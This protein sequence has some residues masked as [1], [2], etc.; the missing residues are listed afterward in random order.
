[1]I[2]SKNKCAI[3]CK[4]KGK[5]QTL[6]QLEVINFVICTATCHALRLSSLMVIVK[7]VFF[8]LFLTFNSTERN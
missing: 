6:V 1:V 7:Y 3:L 2:L 5:Y 8:L 4:R